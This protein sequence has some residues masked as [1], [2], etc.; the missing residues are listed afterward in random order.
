MNINKEIFRNYFK[1]H[2]PSPLVKDIFKADESKSDEFKYLIINE[3]SKITEDINL[4]IIPEN[5][6]Q[7][8]N[9][10]CSKNL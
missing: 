2:T 3:L 1:Y 8:S 7:T 4:K 9:Q 10:Y 6:I 5:E